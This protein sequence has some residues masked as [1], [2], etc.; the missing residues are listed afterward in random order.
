MSIKMRG[1]GIMSGSSLD[2]VDAIIV[3]ISATQYHIIEKVAIP[4][5]EKLKDGLRQ[6]ADLP[7]KDYLLLES[8]YSTFLAYAMLHNFKSDYDYI[9]VH[10]HT[11]HHF[12]EE[13]ISNQM[14]NGAILSA[15]TKK[16]VITDFRVGDIALGGK[17]TPMVTMAEKHLFKGYDY[18]LN[19]G[20]IANVSIAADWSAY[21]I[22]PCNQLLNYLAAKVDLD[23]DAEGKLS[24][25]GKIDSILYNALGAFSYYQEPSP[26]SIDN[27]WIK[28]N[29]IPLL[30]SVIH[31]PEALHT[32]VKWIADQI[33]GSLE[34][35]SVPGSLFI[36]GG[37]THNNFLVEEI[38]NRVQ[39]KNISVV[40]PDLDIID[41][42]EAIL[43]AYL[44]YLRIS[45]QP[46]LLHTVTG[47][48]T[49]SIGGAIYNVHGS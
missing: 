40:I 36:T 22:C 9:A 29:Y 4:I 10:G 28:E 24:R 21:D 31:V 1:L 48:S 32:S 47:A 11:T 19:L 45:N 30:D 46:N 13:V 43:M 42:K 27:N 44:G 25:T 17:G 33:D 35:L 41:F 12:P 7:L 5:P 20:G 8:E 15:L 34:P 14:V 18:Y 39:K 3:D 23:Y 38:S 16:K 37:G 2:A 49:N 6:S 26:K